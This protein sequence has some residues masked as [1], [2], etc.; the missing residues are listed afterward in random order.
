[1]STNSQRSEEPDTG[2]FIALFGRKERTPIPKQVR[3]E[4]LK[5]AN[6][7]CEECGERRFLEIHHTTYR[8]SEVP[9][10]SGCDDLKCEIF[11]SED[12]SVLQAL[13]RDCHRA[14]HIGPYGQFSG[15]IDQVR[16]DWDYHHHMMDKDD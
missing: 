8:L 9:G 1:M 13:C 6:G 12:A 2:Y 11:G 3:R 14:A 7:C 5:R 4:V 10:F 16:A 15:D